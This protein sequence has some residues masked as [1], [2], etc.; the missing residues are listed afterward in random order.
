MKPATIVALLLACLATVASV[1]AGRWSIQYNT[2]YD[3][4]DVRN[5]RTSS[6]TACRAAC[7]REAECF[8]FSWVKPGYTYGGICFMK[9]SYGWIRKI[10]D[11]HCTS[12][13]YYN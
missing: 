8:V 9:L 2:C 5:V 10:N 11:Y 1:Q 13:R 4:G 12:G 6:A 3:G 7:D